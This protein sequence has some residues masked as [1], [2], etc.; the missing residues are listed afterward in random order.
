[1]DAAFDR[2]RRY[3]RNH[4]LRPSDVARQ[5]VETDIADE[6]VATQRNGADDDLAARE[7]PQLCCRCRPRRRRQHHSP[8][9]LHT[10]IDS[11]TRSVPE[12]STFNDPARCSGPR[13]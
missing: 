1:M 5:I 2:P 10:T 7:E 12:E 8:T 11:T 4:D 6:V 9:R 13:R 3:T